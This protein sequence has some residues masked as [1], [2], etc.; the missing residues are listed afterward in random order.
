MRQGQRRLYGVVVAAI[1]VAL[2]GFL[3]LGQSATARN[4]LQYRDII[5]DSAPGADSN[6]TFQFV[7]LNEIPPGSTFTFTPP[8]GFE[9]SSDPDTFSPLRNVELTVNGS[10]RTVGGSG[11]GEDEVT[12]TPGLGGEITYQLNAATGINS[13][14]QIQVKIGN[15]TASAQGFSE[16]FSTS[17]G[18]TTTP[19]DIEPI[20]NAEATGTQQFFMRVHDGATEIASAGFLIALVERVGVGPVDTT[21]EIP[22]FR[23]NGAPTG[24]I[25]GTTPNVEISLETDEFATCRYSTTAGTSY[26]AMT[27][28]FTTT[29]QLF[30]SRVVPVLPD[31]TYSFYVR[32]VD[33]ESNKNLDDY[34][35][36]FTVNP[37]PTG[38]ANTTGSSTGDGTGSGNSGTGTGGGTG[39]TSGS[40]NGQQPATGGSSGSG[41][42]GGGGGG[43]SG[44]GRG[45]EGGGGFESTDAPY[46]S[47]DGQVIIT[48]FAPPRSVVS[49]LVDGKPAARA[50]AGGNGAY[51]VTIDQI[52]RGVYTFSVFATDNQ[53]T[54][55]GAYSTSFTVVGARS[56]ALS[57]VHLPPS[58][59][60]APDPV[61]PGQTL[62]ISGAALPNAT[63]TIENERDGVSA[64]RRQFTAQSNGSGEWST[65]VDTAGFQSGTY[66]ARAKAEQASGIKTNYS[67]YV[68]YGVG[69]SASRTLTSDLN[70]DG[71]VNL[72]DFSILLFWWNSDGGT[73]DPSAD[74]NSDNRVNLTDFSI[75]LFNWTG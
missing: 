34:E 32:C 49:V 4:I 24:F 43:G 13:N 40:S 37:R 12:I 53:N 17:T 66:K 57:N 5:S 41:G 73:S 47:G 52:A 51:E 67:G 63:I 3:L 44:G 70:R 58:V 38:T 29:G 11:S 2:A 42:S 25:S 71:K 48:G 36:R 9:V 55:T 10:V 56:S 75:L 54:R 14:S 46:R 39:G 31:T 33:D 15:H 20:K 72:T 35:I 27:L 8:D 19:A 23:F 62:T 1:G 60:I 16:A 18:T 59:R 28:T 68:T 50:N 61:N 22:P 69:Q 65:T 45:S 21:E 74:I 30:H 7:N 26:D 6:H 64:S